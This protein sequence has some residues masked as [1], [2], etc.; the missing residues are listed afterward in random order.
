MFN[1]DS[2]TAVLN[3]LLKYPDL[4]YSLDQLK[5]FM[6]SSTGYQQIY[7]S[8]Q[9]LLDQNLYPDSSLVINNL[10]AE[11]KLDNVGGEETLK[12]IVS[13]DYNKENLQEY[14]K[15]VKDDYK[16]RVI[17]SKAGEITARIKA[18]DEVSIVIDDL[19][20]TIENLETTSGGDDTVSLTDY[21]DSGFNIIEEKMKNPGI[22]GIS[23]GIQDIDLGTNG[24]GEGHLWIIAGRPGMGKTQIVLNI[25]RKTVNRGNR[26][27]IF[28]LEM[29]KQALWE[30]LLGIE[31][32]INTTDIGMGLVTKSQF[33]DLKHAK[34]T[35]KQLPIY[36]D[37]NSYA[38]IRY[39]ETTVKKYKQLYDVN[40]VVVDYAQLMCDRGDDQ[41]AELGRIS[42]RL[43][44]LAKSLN[45]GIILLSQINR[46]NESRTDKRPVLADL[47]QSGNLEEDADLVAF[48]YRD[49]YY[50]PEKN[51]GQMEWITRK[52]RYAPLTTILLHYEGATSRISSF[53]EEY[54]YK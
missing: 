42:N 37:T 20:S 17:V 6:F 23:T 30:R 24:I 47:R 51:P 4:G 10:R 45:I 3:I 41:T 50:D 44:K 33:E 46:T 16:K 7:T 35:L 48:V 1:A 14:C 8:Y 39:I 12:Y 36:M 9:K 38:D 22:S 25:I 49:D 32:G 29:P 54:G 27:L 13:L 18:G 28:E 11:N 2:E 31:A 34:E 26:A 52:A 21:A 19:Q 53:N 15:Q 40:V 43:K 5:N